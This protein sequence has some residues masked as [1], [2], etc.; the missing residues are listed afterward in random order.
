MLRLEGFRSRAMA[1][2]RSRQQSMDGFVDRLH[3]TGAPLAMPRCPRVV[4]GLVGEQPGERAHAFTRSPVD[5]VAH[6]RHEG[7]STDTAARLLEA[8]SVRRRVRAH[9]AGF[10][11]SFSAPMTFS[12]VA[13][14]LTL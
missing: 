7:V 2:R 9:L 3:A 4:T 8:D 6:G 13:A 5:G 14:G 12:K 10:G 1:G 11:K